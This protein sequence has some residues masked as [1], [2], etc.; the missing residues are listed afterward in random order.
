[1]SATTARPLGPGFTRLWS[2]SA[3]SN[4]ADGVYVVVLPL[5]AATL[6]RSPALVAGIAMAERL[7]WLLFA[8]P[9][10]AL[11]DRLDRRRVM[12]GVQLRRLAVIG[13]LAVLTAADLTTI[14]LL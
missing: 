4:V 7:P 12:I 11:A 10:G 5:L 1:M 6:T 14:W 3:L 8:L 13:S 9:A 2:A